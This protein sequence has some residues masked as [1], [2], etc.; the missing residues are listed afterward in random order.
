[1]VAITRDLA[2]LTL[3]FDDVANAGAP[4]D[5]EEEARLACSLETSRC[6]IW[7]RLLAHPPTAARILPQLPRSRPVRALRK[8]LAAR[9][10]T[11]AARAARALAP[12]AWNHDRDGILLAD[13]IAELGDLDRVRG[14]RAL[15]ASAGSV[16]DELV[17]R[18]LRLVV[19]VARRYRHSPIG[20]ADAIQEGNL[21]LLKAIDRFDV[22]RGFRLST[23]ASW[24]IRHHIVRAIADRGRLVR[25]PVHRVE[26]LARLSKARRQLGSTPSA[27]ELAAATGLRLSTVEGAMIPAFTVQLSLD[28]PE[29][30]QGDF[31]RPL[32]ESLVDPAS[33]VEGIPERLA[34]IEEEERVRAA[35]A[36][37][38][39]IQAA[40]L[41][42]R[43]GFDDPDDMGETLEAI[44]Q[45]QNLSRERIR[46]IQDAGLRKLR[47]L[48][49]GESTAEVKRLRRLL[50][51]GVRSARSSSR[52]A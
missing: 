10:R 46:Q 13:V 22:H 27:R 14:L 25:Q 6:Q 2:E 4:P 35:L 36:A 21:G 19:A 45:R 40:V 11:A 39:P 30:T 52:S 20:F 18:N 41:R 5:A 51:G 43:F 12:R 49:G 50:P 26:A 3:Y 42:A 48:L 17:R 28:A 33:E 34:R 8:A 29:G 44:G 16:R 38:A 37:L 1:M 23:Y 24:W 15:L 7:E 9:D 31:D 32:E 47:L